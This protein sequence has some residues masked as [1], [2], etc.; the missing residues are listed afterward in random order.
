V[1][2]FQYP[3]ARVPAFP[4]HFALSP[5]NRSLA[6]PLKDG[7]TTNIWTVSAGGGPFRRVT[8]FGRRSILIAR[9]ISWSPDGAFIYA[10]VIEQDADVVLL[11]GMV[12]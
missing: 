3:R 5:D 6:M 2:L 12:R 9:Q 10:A 1:P 11:G 8:D 4:H 7:A